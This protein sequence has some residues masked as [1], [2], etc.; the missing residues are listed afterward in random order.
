MKECLA[1]YLGCTTEFRKWEGITYDS[2][3]KKIYTALSAVERGMEDNM[4]NGVDSKLYDLGGSNHLRVKHNKC[5]CVMEM[6]VNDNFVATKAKML[7][8]GVVNVDPATKVHFP[9]CMY[10]SFSWMYVFFHTGCKYKHIWS[11]SVR[12]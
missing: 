8:C 12:L 6:E 3:N 1:G 9:G 5:G 11:C 2:K 10:S 4:K 7:V